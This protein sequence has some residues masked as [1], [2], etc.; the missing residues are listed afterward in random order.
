VPKIVFL[1]IKESSRDSLIKSDIE[2]NETVED[3]ICLADTSVNTELKHM[4]RG[5]SFENER[6]CDLIMQQFMHGLES[7]IEP[8]EE[9]LQTN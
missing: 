2:V 1:R 3:E 5:Q 9:A 4:I 6:G 8:P 7:F